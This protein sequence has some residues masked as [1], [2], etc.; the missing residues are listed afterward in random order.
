MDQNRSNAWKTNAARHILSALALDE[1]I[2]EI[3]IFK[4]ALILNRR[5]GSERLS[6]D[7]DSNL[8]Q[9]FELHFPERADQKEYLENAIDSS[10]RKYFESQDPVRFELSRL[11]IEPNPKKDHPHGWNGFL[12]NITLMDNESIGVHVM[13]TLT[14]DI[15]AP[16]VITPESISTLPWGTATIHAYTLERIA[17][18]KAR[19]FLSSLP[20][21][22]RKVRKRA[23]GVRAKDLY[24]LTKIEQEIGT[25]DEAFWKTAG[26][27]FRLACKSRFI[28][29]SGVDSFIEDWRTT[30]STYEQDAII[31]QDLSF[32]EVE[33]ALFRIVERWKGMGIIPFEFPL[34]GES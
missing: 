10:I 22:R 7:I 32:E 19:A 9:S 11:K 12:V 24:D 34:P 33:K 3:L 26:E 23:A 2:R 5:L 8:N 29:C 6:L 15:A 18:E 13:P 27:E 1:R 17:G 4:G 25:N 28:D 21:Y 16:E 31:P 20:T 30:L 14:I